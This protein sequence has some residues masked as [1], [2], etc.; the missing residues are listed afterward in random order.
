MQF[1]VI[2]HDYT[3][4]DALTRRKSVR[5]Q[6]LQ[7]CEESMQKGQQLYGAALLNEEGNMCGSV[8]IVDFPSRQ[9]LDG[10]LA[11]EPYVTARVWENIHVQPCM[12]GSVFSHL[13]PKKVA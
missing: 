11:I 7:L 6:H 2:A 10:W 4:E 3:D 12:V 8:M 9:E 13:I 5:E 1:V